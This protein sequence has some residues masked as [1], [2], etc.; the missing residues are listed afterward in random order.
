MRYRFVLAGPAERYFSRLDRGLQ[1]RILERLGEL[2]L[3][4]M[5]PDKSHPLHGVYAGLRTSRVGELRII[6]RVDTE[7]SVLAVVAIGPRGD[8]YKR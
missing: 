3:D 6:Y 5:D 8:V 7:V 1:A 2:C 4:P